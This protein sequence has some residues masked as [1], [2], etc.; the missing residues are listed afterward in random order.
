MSPPCPSKE[1]TN[2]ARASG[3]ATRWRPTSAPAAPRPTRCATPGSRSS[4][5]PPAATRAASCASSPLM[6]RRAR[7]RVR[8]GRLDG[9]RAQAPGLVPQ[10]HR[11]PERRHH[12]GRAGAVRRPRARD[13]RRRARRVVGAVRRRLPA[14]R[15]VPAE[16][17]ADHP[18]ADR[19]RRADGRARRWPSGCSRASRSRSATPTWCA[20]ER[21]GWDGVRNF[22]ARNYMRSMQVG[23]Q[24]IFYHSNAKPPGAAGMC[25]VVKG[26]EPDP[27][28]FEPSLE[29][30][31]PDLAA[32]RSALGLGDGGAG[33][34]AALRL[35][36]RD[37]HDARAG[38]LQA[39]GQGQPPV[40]AAADRRRVH[41]DRRPRQ[42]E[43]GRSA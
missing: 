4:S 31:R 26:A 37:A 10:P 11:R 33:A 30:L 2:R 19:Q 42:E 20:C 43:A 15:R 40:G 22:M 17:D 29:V 24:A 38:R 41:G 27:T 16:D 35:A 3:C 1:S 23:D 25:K 13:H 18:G 28:Q 32:R 39:A 7:R 21:E 34:R 14:V 5:S 12:P 9:R 36:R 8:A 6:T